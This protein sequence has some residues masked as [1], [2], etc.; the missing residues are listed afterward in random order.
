M[1]V[2]CYHT[3]LPHDRSHYFTKL[4]SPR[5]RNEHYNE[6]FPKVVEDPQPDNQVSNWISS[7]EEFKKNSLPNEK[8]II[9]TL[10]HNSSRESKKNSRQIDGIRH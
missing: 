10:N 6:I 8:S 3:L 2:M 9:L 4:C 7:S 1:Y 5:P